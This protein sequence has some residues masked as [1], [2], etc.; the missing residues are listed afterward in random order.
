M[1]RK[2]PL[3][4]G[5]Y[6]HI[7]NRGVDKR[8]IFMDTHDYHRF[9]MLIYL[10]NS[11]EPVDL[12]KLFRE[13]RTFTEIFSVPREKLLVDIGAWVLMPNHFHMVLKG[14][15]K[16]GITLFLRKLCTGYSTY[17]NLKYERSGSLFQGKFKSK[18]ASDDR[19]LKYLFS[20]VHLNPIKL[21]SGESN[22]KEVG[23]KNKVFA[24]KFINNYEYSSLPDYRGQDRIYNTIINKDLFLD[25]HDDFNEMIKNMED[26]LQESDNK[27][28]F[29]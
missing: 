10:C 20:Y 6:F 19:F 11:S 23:L 28:I 16:N 2:V 18:H 7:Y 27:K 9:M 8:K 21:I 29:S 15:Q 5:E 14:K 1:E 4:E 17:I 24:E 25:I 26:W 3:I 12:Q 13:G 22:W